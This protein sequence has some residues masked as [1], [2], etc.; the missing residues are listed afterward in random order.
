MKLESH[1]AAVTSIVDMLDN[2]CVVSGSYDKCINV[3]NINNEGRIE[4]SLPTNKTSVTGIILNSNG[5]KM[6]SC[7]LDNTLNVWQVVRNSNRTLNII[8]LERVIEN[9]TMICSLLASVTQPD[10]VILGAK[11]GKVKLINLAKGDSYKSYS[12]G[13]NA[14]IEMAAVERQ[15]KPSKASIRQSSP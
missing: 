14:V 8:F 9:N 4:F 1:K 2:K 11:D 13:S 15:S 6:V 12:V 5:T 7:G 10:L 3:Y